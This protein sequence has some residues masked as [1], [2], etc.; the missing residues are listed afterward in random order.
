MQQV[1]P[2]AGGDSLLGIYDMEADPEF[3]IESKGPALYNEDVS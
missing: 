1:D 3:N 2:K